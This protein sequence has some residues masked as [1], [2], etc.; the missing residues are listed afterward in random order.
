MK[1]WGQKKFASLASVAPVIFGEH[2]SNMCSGVSEMS[3]L[4]RILIFG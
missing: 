1:V 3:I 4:L 2:L